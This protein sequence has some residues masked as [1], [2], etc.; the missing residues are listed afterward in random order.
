MDIAAH[1]VMRPFLQ[2][3]PL[4]DAELKEASAHGGTR[5]MASLGYKYLHYPTLPYCDPAREAVTFPDVAEKSSVLDIDCERITLSGLTAGVVDRKIKLAVNNA[6]SSKLAATLKTFPSST[7][8]LLH[9]CFDSYST[10]HLVWN[11]KNANEPITFAPNAQYHDV[12]ADEQLTAG[13]YLLLK[14]GQKENNVLVKEDGFILEMTSETYQALLLCLQGGF[15]YACSIQ[16]ESST[17]YEFE[18]TF[19]VDP[20]EDDDEIVEDFYMDGV[21]FVDGVEDM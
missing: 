18:L 8:F 2:I 7:N 3:I 19:N 17:G 11:Y 13:S 6:S 14:P 21:T 16:S 4:Y 12:D 1:V 10:G 20:E 5:V 15:G 9:L